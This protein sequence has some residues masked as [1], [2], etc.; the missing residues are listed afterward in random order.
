MR[1][2]TGRLSHAQRVSHPAPRPR[3]VIPVLALLV[4]GLASCG[5]QVTETPPTVSASGAN[6]AVAPSNDEFYYYDGAPISLTPDSTQIVIE[7]TN[8]EAAASDLRAAGLKVGNLRK[9]QLRGNHWMA[10]LDRRPPNATAL[11]SQLK[12]HGVTFVSP[13]YRMTKNNADFIPLNRVIVKF[14]KEV[15]T[16]QITALIRAMNLGVVRE[17]IPEYGFTYY[18]LSIPADSQSTL[19]VA[20]RLYKHPLVE[21]ADPDRISPIKLDGAPSDPYYS[22]QY[23]LKNTSNSMHGVAVDDNVEAAWDITT[24]TWSAASGGLRV[25]VIGSGVD[26]SHPEFAG[27]VTSGWDAMSCYPGCSDSEISPFPTRDDAHETSVAGIIAARHN[28]SGTAGIA[29]GVIIISSRIIR[30]NQPATPQGVADA[31]NYTWSWKGAMII[32]NSW[33]GS[34]PSDVVRDAINAAMSQGR[35][36]LGTVMVF[37][38]GNESDRDHGIIEPVAWPGNLPGVVAVGAIDRWGNLTNYTTEGPEIAI[39]APSGHYNG[40]CNGDIVTTDLYVGQCHD[41]PGGDPS[42]TSRFS[43][44]SAAA[45]QV[46]A[47]AALILSQDANQTAATIKNRLLSTAVPWGAATQYGYGKVDALAAVANLVVNVTGPTTIKTANNYSWTASATGGSGLS[48]VW[49]RSIDGGQY[50]VVGSGTT[51]SE[52][53]D[54]SVGT[55]IDFKVIATGAG[56]AGQKYKR[57]NLIFP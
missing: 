10:S 3:R 49:E 42:Y 39:V 8:P 26:A 52:Y 14:R 45:P 6:A 27:S 46:S 12:S 9:L 30:D 18:V 21:W 4:A 1:R 31:I 24:G 23:H 19:R 36:G 54:S 40:A 57:V 2:S 15:T 13:A 44:T 28:G 56:T 32:N 20:A 51:H 16:P 50:Q 37:S 11:A 48:Y 33:R 5:D 53:L 34:T 29:P 17:P 55:T 7:T 41:G 35:G 47:V 22:F 43:G 38:A 25:G